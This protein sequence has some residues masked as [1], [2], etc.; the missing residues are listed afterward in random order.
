M[1]KPNIKLPKS[2]PA[3]TLT[4]A[5]HPAAPDAVPASQ[6]TSAMSTIAAAVTVVTARSGGKQHGRTVTAMLSLSAEPPAILVSITSDSDLA[7]TIKTAGRF[8]LSV[9]A[10]GQEAVADAFAG[11][12]PDDRFSV[13]DWNHWPSGQPLL[14]GTLTSLDCVLSGTIELDTHTLFAGIVTHTRSHPDRPPLLWQKR[15][16]KSLDPS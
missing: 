11:W 7:Q 10:E 2:D 14:S 16:Y 6:F 1:T 3:L 5:D 8:S 13:S 15:G 4:L 9:L 12:G